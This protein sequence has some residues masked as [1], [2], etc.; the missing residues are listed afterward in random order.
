LPVYKNGF[1]VRWIS[2]Y[3]PAKEAGVGVGTVQRII[4][5]EAGAPDGA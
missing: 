3:Q 2:A 1:K 5:A 4:H